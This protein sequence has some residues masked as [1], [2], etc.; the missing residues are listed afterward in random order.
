MD[1]ILGL[2]ARQKAESGTGVENTAKS[3]EKLETGTAVDTGKK[4]LLPSRSTMTECG[5]VCIH[6]KSENKITTIPQFVVLVHKSYDK[7]ETGRDDKTREFNFDGDENQLYI[8]DISNLT[9]SRLSDT[10]L[11]LSDI[12]NNS[13]IL[14][15]TGKN[16]IVISDSLYITLADADNTDDTRRSYKS[17]GRYWLKQAL[18]LREKSGTYVRVMLDN[19]N[20]VFWC[21]EKS[22]YCN[23]E[24]ILTLDSAGKAYD[25]RCIWI[26]INPMRMLYRPSPDIVYMQLALEIRRKLKSTKSLYIN[27]LFKDSELASVW[28]TDTETEVEIN[29]KYREQC[30]NSDGILDDIASGNLGFWI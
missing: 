2:G 16:S 22:M 23:A 15:Q 6:D 30:I 14:R 12:S 19:I 1:R 29:K 21:E 13:N 20:C 17:S 26:G 28:T 25:E 4:P 10:E 3:M 8:Y 18:P 5:M 24:E 27:I 9:I 7:Y 11:K